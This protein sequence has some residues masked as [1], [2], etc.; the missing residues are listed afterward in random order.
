MEISLEEAGNKSR[1]QR[2]KGTLE[3]VE[4]IK[5]GKKVVTRRE[6]AEGPR[7]LL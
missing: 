5:L 6:M 3:D 7:S 1:V 4:E 2:M